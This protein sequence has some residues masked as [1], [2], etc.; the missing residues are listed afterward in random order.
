MSTEPKTS[1][2]QRLCERV[3]STV[4]Q[5]D[6]GATISS[7][8]RWESDDSTLVRVKT[9]TAS[10]SIA[11]TNALKC[12]WPLANVSMMESVLDGTTEAQILLPSETEQRCIAYDLVME[13]PRVRLLR[14]L[15]KFV[16][17]A[18]MMAFVIAVTAAL[19]VA[20]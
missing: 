6:S 4:H 20:T 12:A 11:M 10:M 7:V 5:V 16:S 15:T 14:Q 1:L 19:S 8:S 18:G 2:A 13:S 9:S 17:F 3:L